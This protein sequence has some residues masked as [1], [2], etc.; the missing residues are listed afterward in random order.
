MEKDISK[1]KNRHL[2]IIYA[3]QL[4]RAEVLPES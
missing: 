3:I 4:L 2:L 1:K